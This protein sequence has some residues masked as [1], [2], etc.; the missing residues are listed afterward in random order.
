[1]EFTNLD[2]LSRVQTCELGTTQWR[3]VTPEQV[4]RFADLTGDHQWIHLDQARA[5][6]ESP[7]GATIVHGS[8]IL[9]LLPVF[10]NE[11][12]RV[13]GVARVV[14]AG[15]E[16]ARLRAP[17]PV[18]SRIRG[19]GRLHSTQP[20]ASGILTRVHMVIEIEDRK[21]PSCTAEQWMVF[22]V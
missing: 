11:L 21:Q 2:E 13:S 17:V 4:Q 9:A 14:N 16:R 5:F 20:L 19:C 22:H 10:V 6:A 12:I 3:T 1:M 8:F 18:G 7:F 15:I